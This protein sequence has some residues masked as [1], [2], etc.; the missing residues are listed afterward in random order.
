MDKHE[1]GTDQEGDL[2]ERLSEE[3]VEQ[4]EHLLDRH[5]QFDQWLEEQERDT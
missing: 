4:L 2:T 5:A 3:D 1:I